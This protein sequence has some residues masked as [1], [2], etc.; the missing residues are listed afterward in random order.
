MLEA[1]GWFG[2]EHESQIAAVTAIDDLHDRL[3]AVRAL[4]SNETRLGLLVGVAVG[5]ELHRELNRKHD[6]EKR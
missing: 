5:F 3:A 1:G 4:V 6:Q 2:S